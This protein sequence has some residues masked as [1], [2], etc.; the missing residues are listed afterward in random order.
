MTISRKLRSFALSLKRHAVYD[1]LAQ[2]EAATEKVPPAPCSMFHVHVPILIAP[3]SPRIPNMY[4]SLEDEQL[5]PVKKGLALWQLHESVDWMNS[6]KLAA[7]R[8]WPS[9]A[10]WPRKYGDTVPKGQNLQP[11]IDLRTMTR[12]Y[13]LPYSVRCTS[14]PIRNPFG[15]TLAPIFPRNRPVFW[16]PGGMGIAGRSHAIA[17][18]GSIIVSCV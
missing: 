2:N 1:R 3:L 15:T 13:V 5:F 6:C 4:L 12:C 7:P 8:P 18:K 14:K 9:M 17:R 11:L 16:C 10:D